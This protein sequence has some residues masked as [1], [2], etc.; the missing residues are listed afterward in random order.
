M[1][2]ALSC[3]GHQVRLL[4]PKLKSGTQTNQSGGQAKNQISLQEAT[5]QELSHHYGLTNR[6][7]EGDHQAQ[8]PDFTIIQ[9]P[10]KPG[11]RHYDF[12]AQA[13][14]W[15]QGWGSD[16]I[17]TRLPQAAGAGSQLGLRIIYELHDLPQGKMGPWLFYRFLKGKGARRLVVI[18]QSL[19]REL[20]RAFGSPLPSDQAD[21]FTLVAPDGV[22][23]RRYVDIP[24]PQAARAATKPPLPE[25]FTAGY[26]GHLYSGRGIPLLVK[27]A[28]LLP[29]INLLVVG[30]EPG[31]VARLREEARKMQLENLVI[32]G[33]VPNAELPRYQAACDALLMPYQEQVA[34]SSGGDI[35]RYLS[36]MKVF[37]YMACGRPILSSNL[38]V[39]R[40]VLNENNAIL[41]PPDDVHAWAAAL[42]ELQMK[43]AL[44]GRLAAQ[45]RRDAQLYTWETR[46]QRIL[47]GVETTRVNIPALPR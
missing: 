22:D 41:L 24:S 45:A 28:K 3:Q 33:F 19:A 13:L 10:A 20:S 23:L 17:Y 4:V 12:S 7:S 39:L 1:T 40:E 35:A 2:H 46:A 26:T 25:R 32:T 18:T 42:S 31:D 9:L 38:P 6:C 8:T 5:W 11:L 29:H 15:A 14:R 36:P 21:T 43:P 34:A 44:G 30:G 47:Q 27:L 16:I 37:E